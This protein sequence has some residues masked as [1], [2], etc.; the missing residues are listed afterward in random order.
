EDMKA[1]SGDLKVFDC[2]CSSCAF[3]HLGSIAHGARF[4]ENAMRCLAPGGIAVH[5]T[6]FNLTSNY[7]TLESRDLVIFR[8]HDIEH[9]VRRLQLAGHEIFPLNLNPGA[10]ELDPHVDLP[11]S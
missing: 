5:T 11:S 4:V 6:E 3:E 1:I 9:L 8:K 2:V 7:Q 10:R